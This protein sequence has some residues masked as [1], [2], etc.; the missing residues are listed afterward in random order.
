[1]ILIGANIMK[2]EAY[3]KMSDN[4]LSWNL[5]NVVSFF[6]THRKTSSDVY[7]SE[8]FFLEE[9][10]K[11]D[12][13]VLDIGC[14]QGGFA[15]IISEKLNKFSYTGI[16]IS[17]NMIDKAVNLYP[18]H[19]FHHVEEDNLSILSKCY[20]MV[21]LLGV[22]H[23][24]EKWRDTVSVAWKHTKSVLIFDLRETINETIEDKKKSF[25]AMDIY[26]GNEASSD[27]LPYNLINVSEAKETIASICKGASKISYYG[28]TQNFETSRNK[29]SNTK[30]KNI[31]NT[32]YLVEK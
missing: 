23:V 1:M 18:Q 5:P 8:R 10:L 9:K 2:D 31:I 32:T 27:T 22:L 28:Y 25:F 20:D 6:D 11:E 24:H 29:T 17:K 15:A 16:D 14:A 4:A 21:M 26:K 30:L 13:S 12:I 3:I 7:P 19:Q